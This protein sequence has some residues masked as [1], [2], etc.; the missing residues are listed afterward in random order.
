MSPDSAYQ[1]PLA[2][3]LFVSATALHFLK[4]YFKE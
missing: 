2:D 4:Q 1:F 3:E